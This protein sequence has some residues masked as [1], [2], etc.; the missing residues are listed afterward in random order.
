M[1]HTVD[2][3]TDYLI[4]VDPISFMQFFFVND[5]IL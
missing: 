2:C 1:K 5:E 4:K 3:N